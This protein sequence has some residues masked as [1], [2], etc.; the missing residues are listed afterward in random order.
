MG[1][2]SGYH[3]LYPCAKTTNAASRRYYLAIVSISVFLGEVDH[4]ILPPL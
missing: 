3:R 2:Q 1:A 4:L